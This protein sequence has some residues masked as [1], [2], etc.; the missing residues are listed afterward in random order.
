MLRTLTEEARAL[1]AE[2]GFP[3]AQ[4]NDRSAL[5][6]LALLHLRPGSTWSEA[7][8]PMMGVTPIMGFI[9]E[10]YDVSYAPNSRETFRRETLHQFV[11]AGL[12]C[13][14]PDDPDRPVN[15]PKAVYQIEEHA[16]ELIK[17][18]GTSEWAAKLGAYHEVQQTLAARYAKAR[19][20][21]KIPV[22]IA[23][24][25]ELLLSPGQHSQL[26][27]AIIEEFAPRFT[28]G[29]KLIYAGDTGDKWGYFDKATLQTLGVEIESHGKMPD[30]VIYDHRREW[31]ILVESVTSHGPV[32]P[33]RQTELSALFAKSKAGLVF[34]TAFSTRALMARFV[35]DISWESEVWIAEAPTHLI[36][37]NGDRF[38]GPYTQGQKG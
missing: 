29:A 13:Y 27:K 20:V 33:K 3:K 4:Q 31:L 22:E 38:L 37:F 36:H 5:C 16:L 23:E 12:V 14:N 11:E 7:S 19:E 34:V 18:Q 8:N 30:V 1:L 35:A 32:N 24:G 25:K 9:K 10:A 21:A 15:S 17:Q 28:P 2:L 6:L 26:I